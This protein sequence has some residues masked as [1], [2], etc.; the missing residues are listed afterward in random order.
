MPS[1]STASGRGISVPPNERPLKI[2]LVAVVLCLVCSILVSAAA[3]LLKP[4]QERNAL[5]RRQQQILEVAGIYTQGRPIPEQF[6]QVDVRM[7]DLATGEFVDSENPM[8]FDIR[9]VAR[10]P[11]RSVAISTGEDIANIRRRPT[12][13]PVYL[14][15]QDGELVTVV[16]PVYGYGLWSTMYAYIALE[17]DV[18]TIRGLTF[19]SHQETPGL[20]GEIDNP[21]WLAQWPGK[22]VTDP[23]G[24]V[25]LKVAK[26]AAPGDEESHIDAIA[27]ATLTS[28]GVEQLVR[29]WLG[30][31]GFGPFLEQLR[32]RKGEPI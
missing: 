13:M 5:V 1:P 26:A 28:R 3:V 2:L 7:V 8:A 24:E 4:I 32:E 20:G 17:S 10:N 16:L 25:L 27:G 12:Q 18:Q 6:E 31:Q 15:E 23:A 14:V 9:S 11:D 21:R 19:Y 29:Y 22:V 30:E